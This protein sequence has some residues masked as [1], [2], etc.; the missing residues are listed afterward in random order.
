MRVDMQWDPTRPR[1]L[2]VACSDG[3]LQEATDQFLAAHLNITHYDRLYV[4]G[5]AGALSSSG[6][7]FLRALELQRECNY[8]VELH[9]VEQ[10]I[11]LFHG[12]AAGGPEEAV[13]AD[14]RRKF[15]WASPAEIRAQQGQDAH[16]LLSYRWQWAGRAAVSLYRCEVDAAGELSFVA[17]HVD[18]VP[19]SPVVDRA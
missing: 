2:V 14:Y 7:D 11:A 13:C 9:G 5:G 12:P 15:G 4:P 3:R 16:E 18:A 6:R 10:L 17:L 1:V 19:L 8:L